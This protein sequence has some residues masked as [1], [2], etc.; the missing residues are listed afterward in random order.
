MEKKAYK[1]HFCHF[2][3]FSRSIC[4]KLWSENPAEGFTVR[5][6]EVTCVH[7]LHKL[8]KRVFRDV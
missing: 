2:T 6:R 3:V 5:I 1:V 4:G 8:S 7:C